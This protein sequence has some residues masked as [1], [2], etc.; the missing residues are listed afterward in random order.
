MKMTFGEW[1]KERRHAAGLSQRALAA[2]VGFDH[3]YISKLESDTLW[4][5]SG[6]ALTA[7]ALALDADMDETF[8]AAG[9]VNPMLVHSLAQAGPEYLKGLREELRTGVNPW[10]RKYEELHNANAAYHDEQIN[11]H[12]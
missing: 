6:V 10:R 8:C 12:V 7:F 3:T 1:L 11:G 5:H 9:T 4:T 2:K